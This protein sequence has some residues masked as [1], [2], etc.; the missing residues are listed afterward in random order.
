[1]PN[2]YEELHLLMVQFFILVRLSVFVLV[3]RMSGTI[4]AGGVVYCFVL[5][6]IK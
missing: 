4:I 3:I 6:K 5:F 1:M 2:S